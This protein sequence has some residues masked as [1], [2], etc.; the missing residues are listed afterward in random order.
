MTDYFT[1]ILQLVCL[2]LLGF[3]SLLGVY[4]SFRLKELQKKKIIETKK[5][6]YTFTPKGDNQK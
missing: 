3:T 4:Y 2:A 1:F 5:G 6:T